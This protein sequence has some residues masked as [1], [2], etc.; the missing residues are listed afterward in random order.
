[1]NKILAKSLFTVGLLLM[2]MAVPVY[3]SNV[4]KSVRID[5]GAETDGATSVNGSI[6][7]GTHARVSGSL[8]TVNG[9]IRV[10]DNSMVQDVETVNGS[11]RLGDGV[12]AAAL[13]TVN[14]SVELGKQSTA[15]SIEA[16]NGRIMLDSN[17]AVGRDISNVNGDIVIDGSKVG[18]D[19]STVNGNV[20]LSD[21]AII[22]GDLVV[23]KPSRWSFN[24]NSHVPSIVIGPGSSVAGTIRLERKV[25]LYIS[26]T[27]KIGAVEGEMSLADAIR[28]TGARP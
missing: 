8:K 22:E 10:D 21:A 19:V 23:K 24:D 11:L 16:V 9:K 17:S 7:V 5:D 13:S 20:E 12:S 27:A 3:A 25:K 6:S 4:N 1:M 26:E 15:D 28:F 14:G 18:G 2:L